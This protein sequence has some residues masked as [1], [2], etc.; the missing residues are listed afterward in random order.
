MEVKM[1]KVNSFELRPCPFC[2]S[3]ATLYGDPQEDGDC[4]VIC[5]ECGATSGYFYDREKAAGAWNRREAAAGMWRQKRIR[6]ILKK[7][8]GEK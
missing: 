4:I 3:A 5:N 1:K 8:G 6:H 2:G 7:R